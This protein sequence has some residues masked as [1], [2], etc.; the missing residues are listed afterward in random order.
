KRHF[1]DAASLAQVYPRFAD[2]QAVRDEYD[3]KRLFANEYTER[4]LGP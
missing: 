4:V 2:F 1:Q 3:P